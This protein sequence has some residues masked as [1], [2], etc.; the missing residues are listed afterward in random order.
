ML[1]H[2]KVDVYRSGSNFWRCRAALAENSLTSTST[3]TSTACD[4][5]LSTL[6]G[7]FLQES[8]KATLRAGA[9]RRFI[10]LLGQ[11]QRSLSKPLGGNDFRHA[12]FG[13]LAPKPQA[14]GTRFAA[15][16][17]QV[18]L[19]GYWPRT[20]VRVMSRHPASSGC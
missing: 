2:E 20:R 18:S 9:S 6:K 11:R 8:V 19:R 7:D 5:H 1:A 16:S 4:E 13:S 10:F 17:Y 14:H 3:S 12:L 15:R